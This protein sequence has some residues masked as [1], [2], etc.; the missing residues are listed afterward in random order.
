MDARLNAD[1]VVG[2]AGP[3]ISPSI[4]ASSAPGTGLRA[5]V[6]LTRHIERIRGFLPAPVDGLSDADASAQSMPDASP[7]KWHLLPAGVTK[8]SGLRGALAQLSLSPLNCIG[9]GD[10]ENDLPVAVAN[11]LPAVKQRAAECE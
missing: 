5:S 8:A 2:F 3:V 6:A 1:P 9:V 10:A 11:A 7:S 4:V